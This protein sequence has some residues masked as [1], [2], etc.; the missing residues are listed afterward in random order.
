MSKK[1]SAAEKDTVAEVQILRQISSEINSTLNLDEIYEIVLRT[2]DELFGFKH[3]LI[4]LLDDSESSLAVVASRGYEDSGIGA[5]VA[6]G[7]GVIGVV[8]SKRKM[9]RVGNLRQQRSYAAAV[10]REMEQSG[11][12]SELGEVVELPGLPD[13]NSQIAIPLMIKDALIGVFSV[14]SPEQKIFS[15]YEELLVNIVANQAASAIQNARLY[16]AEEE[17]RLKLAE[18]NETLEDRVQERTRELEQANRELRETQTQLVQ[19]ETMATLGR[20]VAGLTQDIHTPIS[21][22][23]SSRDVLHRSIEKIRNKCRELGISEQ[24]KKD[25]GAERALQIMDETNKIIHEA[26]DRVT[27]MIQSL[28]TFARLDQSDFATVD[29]QEGLNSTIQLLKPEVSERIR[30][31]TNFGKLPQIPCYA[32]QIN[33]VFFHLLTNA[34]QALENEGTI[35]ITTRHDGDSAEVIFSDTGSGI[36]SQNLSRIF[37]PGFTTRGIGVGA[38]LGLSIAFRIMEH[39]GGSIRVRSEPEKGAE[40][41]VRIPISRPDQ[42]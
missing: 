7:T 34:I 24:F 18:L 9:M 19:S 28:K 42:V 25:P 14:E 5:R 8:A 29:L 13:A 33:Q 22:I 16:R 12:G 10:R 32:R 20:L 23:H 26:T 6:V 40:F 1:F 38:G 3:A 15:E 21:A 17:Q 36:P 30:I 39:H 35:T 31:V 11:K 27:R 2:M 41:T 4:L 37:E